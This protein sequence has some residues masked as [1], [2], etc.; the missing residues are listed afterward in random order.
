[1]EIDIT[2]DLY[3]C[4]PLLHEECTKENCYINNGPCR[5]TVDY[6]KSQEYL[7]EKK[8]SSDNLINDLLSRIA[9]L[10]Y[11]LEDRIRIIDKMKEY[12]NDT[13][14][15]IKSIYFDVKKKNDPETIIAF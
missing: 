7:I 3:N 14:K 9:K 13:P 12:L 10:E 8:K 1:M 2:K 4:C 15:V 6:E 5:L 11:E